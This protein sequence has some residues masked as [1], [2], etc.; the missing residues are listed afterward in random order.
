MFKFEIFTICLVALLG[1]LVDSSYITASKYIFTN[2]RQN[3]VFNC[4]SS[5]GPADKYTSVVIK[6]GQDV[7]Y[8]SAANVIGK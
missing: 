6:V 3:V 7:V 5:L 1:T 8:D 4:D 2:P